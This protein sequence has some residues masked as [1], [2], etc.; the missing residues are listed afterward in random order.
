MFRHDMSAF[1]Y[2]TQYIVQTH[3]KGTLFYWIKFR[4]TFLS[5]KFNIRTSNKPFS[6]KLWRYTFDS[7]PTNS[8]QQLTSPNSSSSSLT[9]LTTA[10]NGSLQQ[11]LANSNNGLHQLSSSNNSLQQ[12]LPSPN[13]SLTQLSS[14]GLQQLAASS[15]SL[16]QIVTS[17]GSI[18]GKWS[19]D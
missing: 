13:N 17:N 14:N 8:L 1:A 19:N 4:I 7:L 3:Y 15:N 16:H 12:Q 11:H 10:S 2:L 18:L 6:V 5:I 9:Q